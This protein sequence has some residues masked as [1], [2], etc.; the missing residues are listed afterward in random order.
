MKAEYEL[1]FCEN[2][3]HFNEE[4]QPIIYAQLENFSDAQ[5]EILCETKLKKQ[6]YL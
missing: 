5:F 4:S 3:K 6:I 2:K 1:W